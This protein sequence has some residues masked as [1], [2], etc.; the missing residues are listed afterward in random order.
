MWREVKTLRYCQQQTQGKSLC[1]PNFKIFCDKDDTGGNSNVFMGLV[2]K[3]WFSTIPSNGS[4]KYRLFLCTFIG[5]FY[6]HFDGLALATKQNILFQ[7]S[8]HFETL[9]NTTD[10][11]LDKTGTISS[12]ILQWLSYIGDKQPIQSWPLHLL[13]IPIVKYPRSSN[14]IW[15]PKVCNLFRSTIGWKWQIQY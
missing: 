6:R 8:A 10:V 15:H 9:Q 12:G 4:I 14:S 5:G 7:S 2:A 3:S 11:V 1:W 13:H